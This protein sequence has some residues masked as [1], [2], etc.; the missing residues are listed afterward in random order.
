MWD[1]IV[2][3]P[4]HCFSI[5]FGVAADW[6]VLLCSVTSCHCRTGQCPFQSD[7]LR[8]YLLDQFLFEAQE[9][10]AVFLCS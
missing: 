1:V 5:Y 4:D 2:L 9:L 8:L 7:F 10:A 6:H 3:I